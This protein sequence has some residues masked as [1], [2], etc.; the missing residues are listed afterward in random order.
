VY[1]ATWNPEGHL[2]Q[3]EYAA[4]AV[5]RE[6][7]AV[8]VRYSDGVLFATE[9]QILSPLLTPGANPRIFWLSSQIACVT[10]GERPDCLAAVA[11]AREYDHP[12]FSNFGIH[13][14]VPQVV[15]Q[16]SAFFRS[17][18]SGG[19]RPYGATLLFGG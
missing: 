2:F 16:T 13:L 11:K 3:V 18:H 8:G 15:G 5:D 4:K 9:K 10:V 1:S 6:P 12:D 14:S 7:V 19:G 17:K